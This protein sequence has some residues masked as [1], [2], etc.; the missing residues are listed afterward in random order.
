LEESLSNPD[1]DS[2]VQSALEDLSRTLAEKNHDYKIDGE[3][4]NF[5]YAAELSGSDVLG[6][7][8]TQIGIKLGRLKG[9][10]EEVYNEP[11]IDTYK[12][13]AGY[14]VILYAYVMSQHAPEPQE[15]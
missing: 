2:W 8:M 9:L 5:E 13:L 14:A 7:M 3:F 10:P 15:S 12:D 4:S 11:K 6:V 1:P